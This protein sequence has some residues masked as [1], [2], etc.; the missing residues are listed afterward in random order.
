[1]FQPFNTVPHAVLTH[2]DEIISLLLH[3]C[4]FATVMNPNVN[5]IRYARYLICDSCEQGGLTLKKITNHCS[6]PVI[7]RLDHSVPH[8]LDVLCQEIFS[9]ITFSLTK[10]S[11]SSMPQS[12]SSIPCI[13]LVKLASVAPVRVPRL[14]FA[15][16]PQFGFTLLIVFTFPSIV[17]VFMDFKGIY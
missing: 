11:I 5:I 2:N 15:D 10:V 6:I 17:C 3:N 16:F 8:F 4:D 9:D 12:L 13:L 1:M 14:S 7:L